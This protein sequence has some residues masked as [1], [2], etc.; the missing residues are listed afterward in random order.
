VVVVGATVVVV[1]VVVVVVLLVVVGFAVEL[2]VES[3]V[4]D[5]AGDDGAVIESAADVAVDASVVVG[6]AAVDVVSTSDPSPG[7]D[8]RIALADAD[9][10]PVPIWDR[11][12]ISARARADNPPSCTAT[13]PSPTTT[14]VTTHSLRVNPERRR[15]PPRSILRRSTVPNPT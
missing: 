4:C 8:I 11:G 1:V 2:V 3:S 10:P 9:A 12:P 13:I 7:S 5:G 14:V 6:G 15:R